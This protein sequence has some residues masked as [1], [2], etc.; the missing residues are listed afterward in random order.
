[1]TVTCTITNIAAPSP[2]ATINYNVYDSSVVVDLSSGVYV[3]TPDCGYSV[4]NS[5]AWNSVVSSA[6]ALSDVSASS[7]EAKLRIF[8]NDK[9]HAG[10]FA[11]TLTNALSYQGVSFTPQ[12]LSFSVVVADP[13][14][15]TSILT[16]T[17]LSPLTVINGDTQTRTFTQATL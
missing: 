2:P 3:Q 15:N 10:T 8:S 7:A 5:F 4:V 6:G 11:V 14:T 12:T 17:S 1:M 9:T 13:C 16:P